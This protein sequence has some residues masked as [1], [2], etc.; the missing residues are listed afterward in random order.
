MKITKRQ[1]RKIIKE[2]IDFVNNETGEL[3]IF[4]DDWEK[5]GGHAPEAAAAEILKRLKITP[6]DSPAIPR[7]DG[8]ESVYLEPEDW[9]LVDVEIGGKRTARRSKRK[10][11]RLDIDNLLQRLDKWSADASSDWNSGNMGQTDDW[12]PAIEDVAWDLSD[13]A[14]Y[15]FKEDEWDEL[16]NHFDWNE[17]DL[18]SYIAGSM[19]RG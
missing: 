9:A 19:T 5:S 13:A 2:G 17:E 12:D 1:L 8:V 18:R 10:Q 15:E 7:E 11:E 14:Q 4:E 16:L 6:P 3:I